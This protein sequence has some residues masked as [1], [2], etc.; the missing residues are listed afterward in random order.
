MEREG[1]NGERM[2][3]WRES[4]SF[5]FLILSPFPLH[6]LILSPF[7]LHFLILS[8]FPR[9]LAARLQRVVTPWVSV[10][11]ANPVDLSNQ[12]RVSKNMDVK[13]S[14]TWSWIWTGFSLIMAPYMAIMGGYG[15]VAAHKVSH[16]VC[17]FGGPSLFPSLDDRGRFALRAQRDFFKH[18]CFLAP[19][20][21]KFCLPA[22][23]S[24]HSVPRLSAYMAPAL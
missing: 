10:T 8:P 9:S 13:L 12:V 24:C 2:R 20:I 1:G 7:P 17:H 15:P 22:A 16:R 21:T 3:K 23:V 18:F 19:K 4:F 6:F 14:N 5:S 11:K